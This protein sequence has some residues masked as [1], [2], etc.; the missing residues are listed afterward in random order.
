MTDFLE[1]LRRLKAAATKGPWRVYDDSNDGKTNRIEI[2]A[3]GKTIAHIYRSVPAVDLPN[4][5]LIAFLLNHADQIEAL[6]E[7]AQAAYETD[8]DTRLADAL[9]AINK[10]KP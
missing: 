8:G 3:I 6:V 4:A 9:A 2:V 1:E 7:A 10:D 5:N